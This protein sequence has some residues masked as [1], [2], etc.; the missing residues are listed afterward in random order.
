[1]VFQLVVDVVDQAMGLVQEG[2][3]PAVSKKYS[4]IHII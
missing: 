3:T 1:M 2:P 4:E